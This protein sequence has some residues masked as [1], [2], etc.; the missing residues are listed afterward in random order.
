MLK[1]NKFNALFYLALIVLVLLIPKTKA[2]AA[3]ADSLS[4]RILLQVEENGESWYVN[5]ENNNRYVLGHPNDAFLIM[6]ELG[7]GIS[8]DDL[9]KIKISLDIKYDSIDSD[10]DGLSD[11]MEVAI[12]TNYK[13]TDSDSD[14]FSDFAELSSDFN[15]LNSDKLS[16]DLNFSKKHAGKIFLQTERNG[17][18]WYINPENNNRYFLGRPN[19]AFLI[20]KK[21]GLGISNTDLDKIPVSASVEKCTSFIYSNW[22]NCLPSNKQYRTIMSSLPLS[23]TGGDPIL[24]QNC[25]F[26]PSNFT[27]GN[28]ILYEGELYPSTKIG[29]QCWLAKNINVGE[30]INKDTAQSDNGIIEKYCL[31]YDQANCDVYGGLYQWAET[32]QYKNG[33]SN[34]SGNS[35]TQKNQGICPEGWH[36]PSNNEW[37][38]LEHYL[39]VDTC[40]SSLADW[41]CGPTGKRLKS[42]RTALGP[43]DEKVGI[44][45]SAEPYWFY[46]ENNY[47]INDVGFSAISAGMTREYKLSF[48]PGLGAWFWSA[49]SYT[50]TNAWYF[51]LDATKA[52]SYRSYGNIYYKRANGLS[53]RC[54][55][56]K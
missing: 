19:D 9:N 47:G 1:L 7:I 14:A 45:V 49:T 24:I 39:A 33:V 53:V 56:D 20:M 26:N 32:V 28:N 27:C 22:A 5:P 55:K 40:G 15:P 34:V 4:G 41:Q 50:K 43:N 13:N 48:L 11:D 8:N 37:S 2:I 36:I 31:D 38:T 3:L 30:I 6:K 10:N 17:E 46:D 35:S 16:Y 52:G 44:P 54:L 51:T 42:S 18:A 25:E 29:N 21:L 23:C 12:G